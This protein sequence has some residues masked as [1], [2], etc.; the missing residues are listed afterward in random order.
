M[1]RPARPAV[2]LALLALAGC[3]A[4]PSAPYLAVEGGGFVF[5]YRIAEVRYGIVV[6]P[7]RALP[8]GATIEA[9]FEN[10]S[11]GAPLVVSRKPRPS[12]RRV[13]L[14]SG[15]VAGVVKDEPYAVAVVL[16]DAAG[17]PLQTI[18]KEFRSNIDGALMPE[19]PLTVGPGYQR[20][21]T[22]TG[23]AFPQ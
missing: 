8:E 12:D 22:G 7:V 5:N 9:R 18:E 3:E 23:E 13:H 1:P 4:D 16:K 15:P 2:L 6:K 11:G 17:T 21:V 20:N 19:R 14:E 10:P